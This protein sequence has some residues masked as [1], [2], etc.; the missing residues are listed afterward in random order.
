MKVPVT[1]EYTHV[2]KD[3]DFGEWSGPGVSVSC[4]R[5]GHVVEVL[6]STDASI[7]R[8]CVMLKE[9]C[10]NRERNFYTE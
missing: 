2:E 1:V 3:D 6:G 5:C 9:E 4:S 10:P 7:M 8:G